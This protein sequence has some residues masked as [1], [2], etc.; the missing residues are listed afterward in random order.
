MASGGGPIAA[1]QHHGHGAELSQPQ[2]SVG[3]GHED[4]QPPTKEPLLARVKQIWAKTG[5]TWRYILAI[6]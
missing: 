3:G 1:E 2:K 4:V 6:P 5:I